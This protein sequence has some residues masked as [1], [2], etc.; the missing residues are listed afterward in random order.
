MPDPLVQLA[1]HAARGECADDAT[2]VRRHEC[3]KMCEYA[4]A[5]GM[6]LIEDAYGKGCCDDV[7]CNPLPHTARPTPQ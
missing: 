2:C 7:P 1:N 6:K 3:R 5:D 4:H